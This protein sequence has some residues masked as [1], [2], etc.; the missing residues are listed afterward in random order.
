MVW[1]PAGRVTGKVAF[2][3][4]YSTPL[5]CLRI[6]LVGREYVSTGTKGTT[7]S[8]TTNGK[9]VLFKDIQVLCGSAPSPQEQALKHSSRGATGNVAELGLRVPTVT[10][11][12]G[13]HSFPFDF[14]LPPGI[15]SSCRVVDGTHG[16]Y[17][18]I[19]YEIKA[20]ADLTHVRSRDVICAMHLP[21]LTPMSALQERYLQN[22]RLWGV[23]PLT[24]IGHFAYCCG[25]RCRDHGEVK[26]QATCRPHVAVANRGTTLDIVI[27]I[28]NNSNEPVKAVE[29]SLRNRV[30]VRRDG[31]TQSSRL[32]ESVVLQSLVAVDV[33][34]HTAG[35]SATSI[36][37]PSSML[38][39]NT[40]PSMVSHLIR[41]KW[42]VVVRLSTNED[43]EDAACWMPLVVVP[44]IDEANGAASIDLVDPL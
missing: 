44:S 7:G 15:A 22:D 6:K 18:H 13:Q 11:E 12:V 25:L 32:I 21:V 27:H 35:Q 1:L 39:L 10:L 43:S 17:A 38:R 28:V 33:T 36:S 42:Y 19:T 4:A 2:Q 29:V 8:A 9:V 20:Y 24:A 37:V 3:L 23:S 41:S 34:P 30:V 14:E 40:P 26:V 31:N 16:G 5:I